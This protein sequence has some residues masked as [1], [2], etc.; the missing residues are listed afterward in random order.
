MV[1]AFNKLIE[2]NLR[3]IMLNTRSPIP[4]Y[5]Q[6]SDIITEQI[7]SGKYKPGE[8]IPPETG[9]AKQYKVGRPT[10]RQAMDVL[11]RKGLVE[12]KRGSGTYVRETQTDVD[13]FS[14]AGTSQA[15]FTK[16]IKTSSR[17][18]EKISLVNVDDGLDNPFAGGEA[19]FLSRLTLAGYKPVLLEDIYLHAKLFSGIDSID[20]EN[21]SLAQV[22]NEKFYLKP[23]S[24]K[25]AFKAV[26]PDETRSELLEIDA[27]CPILEVKRM[28]SFQGVED[29]VFSKLYCE[30]KQF[31]FSQ[32]IGPGQSYDI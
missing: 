18:I 20:L 16:G 23:E 4:L 26:F 22:V 27:G 28:L 29:A 13:L 11:V 9:I 6:L 30:T 10:V 1:N 32:T 15:F 17:M 5:H 25:Q 3:L 2:R 21:R 24:G 7:R 8:V 12:R 14:L 19:F 31:S